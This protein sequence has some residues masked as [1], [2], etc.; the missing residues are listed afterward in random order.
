MKK[1]IHIP[2]PCHEDW[3]KMTP[4]QQ[5]RFCQSCSKVVVDFTE[6]TKEE[7]IDVLDNA[8]G[9]TCGRFNTS[10]LDDPNPGYAIGLKPYKYAAAAAMAGFIFMG[11]TDA[12]AQKVGK[13]RIKG[14]VVAHEIPIK[15]PAK[16]SVLKGTVKDGFGGN[17]LPG[18]TIV[19]L[20]DGKELLKTYT[21]QLGTY[22]IDLPKD[23]VVNN[24]IS[25]QAASKEYEVKMINNIE[26]TREEMT[27]DFNMDMEFIMVGEIAI[28]EIPDEPQ[29]VTSQCNIKG[30]YQD[31]ITTEKP[32]HNTVNNAEG[33]G[34]NTKV[35]P[36]IIESV[37]NEQ[38]NN[39]ALT[40]EN[41]G[42]NN[43]IKS[44]PLNVVG[45]NIVSKI[46]PNPAQDQCMLEM[47][48]VDEY[49]YQVYNSDGKVVNMGWFEGAKTEMD[50]SNY[51]PGIYLVNVSSLNNSDH[52]SVVRLVVD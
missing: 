21:D 36:I 17:V 46:Y 47:S 32:E 5:G 26:L 8:S 41:N 31:T 28:R 27:F 7:I 16:T 2:T 19:V 10:Q 4:K 11:V 25:I 42:T 30:I 1:S 35:E 18:A 12:N 13:I 40:P 48:V 29:V 39:N 45:N 49:A 50:I 38:T 23:K 24:R 14:D 33:K 51:A 37:N 52:I 9:N 34:E 22:R 6:K 43:S 44:Q 3:G 15:Q 20:S